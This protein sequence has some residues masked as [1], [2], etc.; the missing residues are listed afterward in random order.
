MPA[1][2]EGIAAH[3]TWCAIE[4]GKIIDTWDGEEAIHL[5]RL[6]VLHQNG[7]HGACTLKSRV[8]GEAEAQGREPR[9][10]RL[11]GEMPLGDEIGEPTERTLC[12]QPRQK[13]VLCESEHVMLAIRG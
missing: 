8:E 9:M 13:F 10:G 5:D 6:V 1:W 12:K 7:R 2:P 4:M 11:S 3:R